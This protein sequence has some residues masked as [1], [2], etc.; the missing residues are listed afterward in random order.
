M[1]RKSPH[2]DKL[3]EKLAANIETSI[4]GELKLPEEDMK[5]V[6]ECESCQNEKL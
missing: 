6:L 2:V 4:Q 5:F 1:K 3:T